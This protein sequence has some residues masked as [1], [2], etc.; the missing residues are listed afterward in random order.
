MNNATKRQLKQQDKF[1]ATTEGGIE[2]AKDNRQ[3]AVTTVIAV[4]ALILVL[5]GAW[6]FYQHRTNAAQTAFGQAMATY[7][8]PLVDAQQPAPPGT[9]TFPD[10]KSRAT[11]ANAQFQDVANRYGSTEPG[12]LALYFTGLTYMEEGQNA[13]AEETLKKVA[14]SWNGDVAALGKLALA[15]LYQQ[16]GRNA[17][18]EPLYN[19]LAKGSATTVPPMEAQLALGDMY[20]AEGRTADANKMY[21]QVKDKDK[22]DKN[23]PGPAGQIAT[24]KLSGKK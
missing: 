20:A 7:Q 6:S 2:W 17:E 9:K 5:V 1:I 21:A 14:G 12:K 4:V 13:S 8:T 15:Q 23:Q 18:A 24:E 16:T 19:E 10:A 3:A 22:D 11:A